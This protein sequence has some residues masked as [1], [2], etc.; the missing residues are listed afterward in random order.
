M[1]LPGPGSRLECDGRVESPPVQLSLGGLS[2]LP[3]LD[4]AER[5]S[6]GALPHVPGTGRDEGLLLP[7]AMLLTERRR[8]SVHLPAGEG[9]Y[10]TADGEGVASFIARQPE[11]AGASERSPEGGVG[12]GSGAEAERACGRPGVELDA[13]RALV[14]VACEAS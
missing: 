7:G 11:V 9:R 1:L 5:E 3:E 10:P 2:I 6:T 13:I 12:S 4:E 8:K 14:Q